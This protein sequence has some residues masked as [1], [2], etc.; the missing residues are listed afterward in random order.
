MK[1][2]DLKIDD[3]MRDY[4]RKWLKSLD[5][6]RASTILSNLLIG[7]SVLF[8]SATITTMLGYD[9]KKGVGTLIFIGVWL[10]FSLTILLVNQM[11]GKLG[12]DRS[13]RS[14][15]M[16]S[17]IVGPYVDLVTYRAWNL[18]VISHIVGFAGS[19]LV[20][21]FSLLVDRLHATATQPVTEDQ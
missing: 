6:P 4:S 18:P 16:S 21:L 10:S 20:F 9:L 15:F 14:A 12:V 19:I 7:F 13:L 2:L 5:I 8:W 17:A 11:L 3:F 1:L